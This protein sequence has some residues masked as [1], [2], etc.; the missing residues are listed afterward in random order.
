MSDRVQVLRFRVSVPPYRQGEQAGF[1]PAVAREYL[2][3][4]LADLVR[5]GPRVDPGVR[6]HDA[7]HR[8]DQLRLLTASVDAEAEY[9]RAHAERGQAET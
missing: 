5:E 2:R 7:R 6:E 1:D 8:A 4:G 3:R 9:F